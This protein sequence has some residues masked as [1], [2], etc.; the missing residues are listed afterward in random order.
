LITVAEV[1]KFV[2][3]VSDAD[4]GRAHKCIA[5]GTSYYLVENSRGDLDNDGEVIEY[6]VQWSRKT[7][8]TCNCYAGKEG[9]IHCKKSF[10]QHIL[11]A[12]AA[13]EEE[14][15]AMAEMALAQAQEA[16]KEVAQ[17]A[18]KP[19][20]KREKAIYSAQEK[21]QAANIAFFANLPK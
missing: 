10:C 2:G 9:F 12:V 20:T 15:K 6:K 16:L 8:F 19:L 21:R 7:A 14:K 13:S 11:I 17:V 1:K 18:A 5:D 4:L 3:E